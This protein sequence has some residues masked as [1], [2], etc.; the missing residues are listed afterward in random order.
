MTIMVDVTERRDLEARLAQSQRMESI[1]RL[2][3]GVAHDF[4]NLLTVILGNC[5]LVL[6]DMPGE[7]Q[8]R[9][10][11]EDIRNAADHAA[12]LTRQLLAFS[13]RQILQP[14]VLSLNSVVTE[15]MDMLARIIGEDIEL[16]TELDPALANTRADPVEM[17]QVVMNLAVNARDAMPE[18]GRLSIKT[19]H[20]DMQRA[21]AAD[22]DT[23]PPGRYVTLSIGDTGIGIDEETRSR[24][25]EPFFTTKQKGKGTGLG[26]STVYGIVKQSGG[27]ISVESEAGKGTTFRIRMPELREDTSGN[28]DVPVESASAGS[29]TILLVEDEITLRTPMRRG[30]E[31]EGYTVLEAGSAEEALQICESHDG[32]IEMMVTDLVMPGM[33]GFELGDKVTDIRPDTRVLYTSGYS[34]DVVTR[35]GVTE[36][37]DFLQKP[38]TPSDLGQRIRQL[39]D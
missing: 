6:G 13:R 18:G 30:L 9:A 33:D 31:K 26:L 10:D 1:G 29:E 16:V 19:E 22:G 15:M 32:T 17:G 35:D 3:G 11:I 24:I 2:A 27:Y 7:S 38:Y 36:A 21:S 23:I 8:Q 12:A 37:G 25:F 39:L 5:E 4:N 14:K 28:N 34:E 20:S